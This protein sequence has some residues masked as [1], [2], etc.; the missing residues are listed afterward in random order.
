[1]SPTAD[2]ERC[3]KLRNLA[4]DL[5]VEAFPQLQDHFMVSDVV[6]LS[7]L[8]LSDGS[9]TTMR[10]TT[11][12]ADPTLLLGMYS[13]EMLRVQRDVLNALENN[14]EDDDA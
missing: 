2:E 13:S 12:N 9:I 14:R 5:L 7:R 4:H 11:L 10:A 6:V 8:T 3:E 1:M